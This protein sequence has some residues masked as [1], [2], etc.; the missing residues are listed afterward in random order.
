MVRHSVATASASDE[1]IEKTNATIQYSFKCSRC[2]TMSV[3]PTSEAQD[4]HAEQFQQKAHLVG[5][6]LR[7][8][9]PGAGVALGLL[10]THWQALQGVYC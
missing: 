3:Q 6:G 10:A 2:L 8:S 7:L 9:F 5:N 1:K 4:E